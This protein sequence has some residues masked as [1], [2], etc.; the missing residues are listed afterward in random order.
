PL[1]IFINANEFYNPAINTDYGSKSY[2]SPQHTDRVLYELGTI[3]LGKKATLNFNIN[4]IPGDKTLNFELKFTPSDCRLPLNIFDPPT[5]CNLSENI[6]GN[7]A[8]NSENE[9]FTLSSNLGST[10]LFEYSLN[11]N[12]TQSIEIPLTNLETNYVFEY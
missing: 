12:A 11:G 5:D 2:L 4:N 9:T 10:A 8:S 3:V 1:D 6:S 7:L